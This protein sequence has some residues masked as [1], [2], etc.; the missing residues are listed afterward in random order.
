MHEERC[1]A[2]GLSCVCFKG[3]ACKIFKLSFITVA[4]VFISILDRLL[5]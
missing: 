5:A 2:Y 4:L 1:L 3:L